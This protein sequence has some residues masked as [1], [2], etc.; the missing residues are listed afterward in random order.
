MLKRLSVGEIHDQPWCPA[1]L[2]DTMTDFLQYSANQ[3]EQYLPAL[4]ILCRFVERSRAERV[5]DLCSGG[6]GPWPRLSGALNGALGKELRIVLTDLYPNVAA[7]RG[8]CGSSGSVLDFHREP[9]DAGAIPKQLSGFR[10]L[11]TS[12]HH[13]DVRTGRAVLQS[14]VDAGEG[15]G[16][17]EM[18]ERSPAAILA[19]LASP[20]FVLLHGITI[21]PFSWRRLIWTYLVP[22][23]PLMVMLDG[24][25]SCLRSYT[26]RELDEL[27][28][29][30]TGAQYH[31]EIGRIRGPRSPF[32][33]T[34]AIG[35]PA[36]GAPPTGATQTT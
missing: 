19:M 18:T 1:A 31:W 28:A 25:A 3:W 4:P 7:F 8:V 9:V 5:V 15:I 29:S 11:F 26:V 17:F 34:Y 23:V 21:R 35:C 12:F 14:A 10:T 33:V 30:L 20:L 22:V 2:R 6:S 36:A 24:I 16:V 32:P 13:F 27:T